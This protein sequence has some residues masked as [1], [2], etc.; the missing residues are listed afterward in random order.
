MITSDI[1]SYKMKLANAF[2]GFS[3]IGEL[4]LGDEYDPEIANEQLMYQYIFPYLYVEGTQKSA[5]TYLCIE[6]DTPRV[7]NHNIKNMEITIWAYCDKNIMSKDI[8]KFY[9]KGY[10]GTR[11]DILSQM[12]EKSINS[13]QRDFGIGN[14]TISSCTKLFVNDGYYGRQM[15]LKI[16]EFARN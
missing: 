13:I 5:K 11:S 15:I 7:S 8:S 9:R 16:P 6:V 14:L 3:D 1:G 2:I 12:I 4:M 10:E